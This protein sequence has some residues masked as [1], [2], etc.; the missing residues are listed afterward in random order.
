[1]I[2]DWWHRWNV[3][4]PVL[5]MQ[6]APFEAWF[7]VFDG[8]FYPE[9]RNKQSE[10][11][12]RLPGVYLTNVLDDGMQYDIHPKNKQLAADRFYQLALDKVY[13][14][15]KHGQAPK[16]ITSNVSD[17]EVTLKFDECDAID[18]RREMLEDVLFVKVDGVETS[19][20]SVKVKDDQLSLSLGQSITDGQYVEVTYQQQSYSHAALFNENKVPFRPFDVVIC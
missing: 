14:Q 19:I 18:C 7:G 11:A 20:V 12:N 9:L 4:F 17:N 3:H 5:V 15:I 6:L 1:M 10:V 2:K 16:L 13:H 8:T